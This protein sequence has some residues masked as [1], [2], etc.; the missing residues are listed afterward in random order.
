MTQYPIKEELLDTWTPELA[1]FLG[2]M[3]TD[4]EVSSVGAIIDIKTDDAEMLEHIRDW[5][6]PTRPINGPYTKIYEGKKTEYVRLSLTSKS[7]A[8]TLIEKYG[9]LPGKTGQER[10]NFAF[11]AD[12]KRHLFRGMFDG[13]GTVTLRKSKK[14]EA[15]FV[16]ASRPLLEQMK[17]LYGDNQGRSIR[18]KKDRRLTKSGEKRKPFYAWEFGIAESIKLRDW[19]YPNGEF[20]LQR[21]KD[22]LALF[23]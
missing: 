15:G 9:I 2:V 7:L 8:N 14:N 13:D 3:I 5:L 21:K 17:Y 18:L 23:S 1:Y 20:G 22:K 12:M 4:G 6:S 19:M 11:P 10:I 16:S